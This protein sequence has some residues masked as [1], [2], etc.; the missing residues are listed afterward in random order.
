MK[1]WGGRFETGPSEVFEQFSGS[2]DFD[3]KL[4][5]ADVEGSRAFAKALARAGIVS[6]AECERLLHAFEEIG[7]EA[8]EKNYFDGATDED[9]HTF[10]I[11]KL[12]EKVGALAGKIHTGR[13]RNEQ[14]SLD[15][16][17][18]LRT[19]ADALLGGLAEL[20]G[21]L[22]SL[23]GKYP[24][25]VIPG[26]THL[27]RAQAV[28]WPHYLLAYFEMFS[29]DFERVEQAR[30]RTNVL[31]LGSG[32]LAGSG[33]PFDRHAIAEDL[34]FPA[35]TRNSMDVSGDRDFALDFLYSSSMIML[36][37]SRLSEDWILYSSE[38]FEWMSL[39]DGVTSGSSLMPQKKNPDSLELIRGKSGRVFGA[40]TSLFITMKGLPM[41]YN[42]DMQEDKE[43]LF[44]AFE[45]TLGALAMAKTVAESV[46]LQPAIPAAAAEESWVVATDLAEELA[47]NGT[48]FHRAHQIVGQLVL[49]SVK[50]GK[51]PSQWNGADLA[52]FAPEF[53]PEMARLLNPVE[54]MKSRELEGGTAPRAV[55]RA[56]EEATTRL[57][58][59]KDRIRLSQ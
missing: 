53:K 34:A 20:M 29:R 12:G 58:A 45:Q 26:Y 1:L 51:K 17:L 37:L 10:V 28:L 30:A 31:P 41:T 43:P 19:A 15:T 9:V 36:H 47:R 48:A 50:S 13:S 42:R 5:F 49:D 25:A 6:A 3:R 57:K 18:Y 22:L 44:E 7:R 35:I 59:L 46:T 8:R 52:E 24:D 32:A 27:R 54:G 39:G 33:F 14:V 23:A 2:L 55:A 56:L 21:A 4:V 16:R 40:L 11:R 38:E